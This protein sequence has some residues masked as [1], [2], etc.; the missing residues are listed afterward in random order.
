MNMTRD[1]RSDSKLIFVH[2][3]K[4]A[5]STLDQILDRKAKGNVCWLPGGT[6]K[7]VDRLSHLAPEDLLR[8]KVFAGHVPLGLHAL[9]PATCRYITI[10]RDPVERLVSH[11]YHVLDKPHH[12]SYEQ[13]VEGGMSL[14]DFVASDI[15]QEVDNLQTR[16]VAGIEANRA[17]PMNGC[18]DE[19]LRTATQ[20]LDTLFDGVLVQEYFDHSL[21]L[22]AAALGWRSQPVYAS[23]RVQR[24]RPRR[25]EIPEEVRKLAASRNRYD[26]SLHRLA[27][28][29][30]EAAVE[31]GGM[32][33]QERL[34]RFRTE[35]TAWAASFSPAAVEKP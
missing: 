8:F 22:L 14:L 33:F 18:N 30:V 27:L 20:N 28:V 29:R 31:A 35:R 12:P 10:L 23:L 2:I 9:I 34:D 3:P 7:T 24:A 16:F 25:R 26:V 4:T 15:S 19:L 5:G 17:T 11:Y 32:E 13:I 1:G 21:L 6:R